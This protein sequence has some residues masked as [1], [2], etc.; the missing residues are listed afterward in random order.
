MKITKDQK[1][2]KTFLRKLKTFVADQRLHPDREE[3]L[4]RYLLLHYPFEKWKELS[5]GEGKAVAK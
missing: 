4:Y 5:E 1:D 3:W 2:Y